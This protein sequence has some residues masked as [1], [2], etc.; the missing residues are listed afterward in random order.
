MPEISLGFFLAIEKI[1]ELVLPFR[2]LLL[3]QMKQILK[4]IKLNCIACCLNI[5]CL[6]CECNFSRKK[7]DY[8]KAIYLP[9]LN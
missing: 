2:N 7:T 5:C 3:Y 1:F 8:E 6:C 9:E 4:H